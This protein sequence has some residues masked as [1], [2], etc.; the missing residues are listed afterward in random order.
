MCHD[1]AIQRPDSSLTPEKQSCCAVR[2]S[3]AGISLQGV[4]GVLVGTVG[5][6]DVRMSIVGIS[7]VG[8]VIW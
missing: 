1:G 6:G 7:A 2:I 4:I 5:I 8:S 3:D